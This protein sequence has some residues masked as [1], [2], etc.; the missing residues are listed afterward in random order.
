ME[1]R[2]FSDEEWDI[3]RL[4]LPPKARVGRPRADDRMVLNG[5]L[6]VLVISCRWMDMPTRY[7][8]HKT[9]W[10][11]LKRWSD[12]GVWYRIFK[13]LASMRRYGRVSVDSSTVEARKGVSL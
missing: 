1:F 9:A 2:E 12:E 13:S 4:L 7:G 6:Y 8:S 5:I 3:I 11:R 10:R